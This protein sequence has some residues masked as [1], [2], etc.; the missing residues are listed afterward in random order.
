MHLNNS[1]EEPLTE[2]LGSSPFEILHRTTLVF[3]EEMMDQLDRWT[4]ERRFHSYRVSVLALEIGRRLSLPDFRLMTLRAG[5]LLHDIGKIRVQQ[6]ILNK[7]GPLSAAEW[8]DMKEHPA[9]GRSILSRIPTLSFAKDV[10]Y[11]HH[12]RWNGTGYPDGLKSEEILFESRIFGVV[13]S[14]DAMVSRRSYNVPQSHG[15]AIGE[16]R[17]NAGILFDP[18]VVD[19]FLEIPVTFF[20][21][22]QLLQSHTRF[23]QDSFNPEEYLS[24]LIP[25]GQ[26]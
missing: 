5:A 13:D 8:A 16:I 18:D 15:E 14:Y 6:E 23:I 9:H 7:P 2:R 17:Q 4:Y 1:K 19:A 3:L 12:E 25:L 10:V 24:L 11:Q 20:D 22:L 21:Q 26:H